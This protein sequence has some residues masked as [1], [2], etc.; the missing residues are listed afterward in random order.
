[1][2]SAQLVNAAS[3]EVLATARETARDSTGILDAVDRVSKKLRERIGE[4]L[5]IIRANAPLQDVTTG[6]LE[7]LRNY[8][9]AILAEGQ[10]DN[11]RGIALLEAAVAHDST[12]AMAWRK[13]GTMLFNEGERQARAEEALTRA[14]ALRNRLTFRERKLTEDSY[15]SDARGMNDSALAA[16]QSLLAEYPS[17]S[18]AMNNLGVAYEM[19]GDE[20]AAEEA[21]VRSAALE[22]ENILAWGNIFSSRTYL[23]Q[24][25]SAASTLRLM[26]ARFPRNA[27][28]EELDILFDLARRDFAAGETRIREQQQR[29]RS[30][31]RAELRLARML[32][33]VLA[34][35]GK[36]AEA[37]R[38]LAASADLRA[39]RGQ[40]GQALLEQARR[41]VP[42]AMYRQDQRGAAARLEATFRVTSIESI[43]ERDRPLPGLIFAAV[44]VGDRD[45]AEAL[46]REFDHN[47]GTTPGRV[48]PFLHA[49]TR[50][51]VL[52]MRRETLPQALE[53][54]RTAQ[55]GPCHYCVDVS[56]GDAFDRAD[57]P[58]SALAHYQRWA[59]AG[60]DFWDGG[61]YTIWQPVAYFRLGELYQQKGDT[62]H[63]TEFY[64]KFAELWKEADPELQPRVRE[65][66]RRIAELVAEP[67]RP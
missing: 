6:S 42:I 34:V 62:A 30:D 47:P 31:P 25:D 21:F 56:M 7:A 46:L 33:G 64:G 9:Q 20:P 50:G 29:F 32:A 35:R 67:R 19:T 28:L 43:A 15:Y 11:P 18:W 52:S 1:L 16:V 54:F 24:F 5:R 58:D 12:F 57:M 36:L 17:D 65:A 59:D 40:P 44:Q 10:G 45:R 51:Q 66:K 61:R 26:K 63:A 48:R 37:D 2:V 27:A 4:S 3:G 23:A 14:F 49:F 55:R 39:E 8:S 13:L 38:A 60:E 53:A 41:V 22:P